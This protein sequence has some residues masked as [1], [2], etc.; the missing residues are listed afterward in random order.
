MKAPIPRAMPWLLVALTLPLMAPSC[1]GPADPYT[2]PVTTPSF[3]PPTPSPVV[4]F[5]RSHSNLLQ[6]SRS[7][8]DGFNVPSELWALGELLV[9]DGYTVENFDETF[10]ATCN[11]FAYV[12]SPETACGDY[13][14]RLLDIDVLVIVS[15]SDPVLFLESFLLRVWVEYHGGTLLVVADHDV[16]GTEQL[17][18]LAQFF[19]LEWYVT[20]TNDDTFSKAKGNL[21]A[22]H[23]ITAGFSDTE[24]FKNGGSAITVLGTHPDAV[25]MSAD[26]QECSNP[27]GPCARAAALTFGS[28]RVYASTDQA[29]WTRRDLWVLPGTAGTPAIPPVAMAERADRY[30]EL[31]T[32]G[33]CAGGQSF[34]TCFEQLM[35]CDS[36]FCVSGN[37]GDTLDVVCGGLGVLYCADRYHLVDPAANIGTWFRGFGQPDYENAEDFA[38]AVMHWL[39]PP[40]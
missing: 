19:E 39:A 14:A 23:P 1:M 20:S 5:D 38:L 34:E 31:V 10:P 8:P 3:S 22:T 7:V 6:F 29:P 11:I 35:G 13:G 17:Q 15:P 30:A 36:N 25:I 12:G 16:F 24:V 27:A 37:I 2:P 18:Y 33:A 4:A 9:A 32:A 40:P 26:P 21:S 28:G